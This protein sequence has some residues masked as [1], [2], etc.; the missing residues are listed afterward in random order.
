LCYDYKRKNTKEMRFL[1]PKAKLLHRPNVACGK[2]EG[3]LARESVTKEGH[4]A[5]DPHVGV[6]KST[7]VRRENIRLREYLF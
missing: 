6:R 3:K 5:D 2:Q 4:V 1:L 7:R